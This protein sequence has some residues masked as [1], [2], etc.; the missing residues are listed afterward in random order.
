[1]RIK[2]Q[3]LLFVFVMYFCLTLLPSQSALAIP[4]FLCTDVIEIPQVECQALVALYESTNGPGWVQNNNWLL[5]NTP[6][7]W[8][9]VTVA[10]GVVTQLILPDNRLTGAIPGELGALSNLASLDLSA[11]QLSGAIP[12]QL[13]S[14]TSL[15]S[16][17]LSDNW[18]SGTI[19]PE[20]G[21]LSI[22]AHLYLN[23]NQLSGAIPP[24]LVALLNLTSLDLSVNQLSAAIPSQLGSLAHLTY[25]DLSY[26]QLTGA[27]PLELGNLSALAHLYLNGNQLSGEIPPALGNLTQ[28]ERLYLYDNFLS[29]S[30]PTSLGNLTK[31]WNLWLSGNQLSGSIPPGFGQ[32]HNMV[33]LRLADNQLSGAIPIELGQLAGLWQL[34]LANNQLTGE[35]PVEFGGMTNLMILSLVGNQL[36]GPIPS[37][38]CDLTNLYELDLSA[39]QLSGSIPP[40]LGNLINL[41]I[42]LLNDNQLSGDIPD[43]TGL[44][45]LIP[46]GELE[47]GDGLNLDYNALTVPT[48]YPDE[49]SAL[50]VFLSQYDLNWHT[51]QGFEQ[52]IGTAGGTLTSLDGRTSITVPTNALINYAIFTFTPLP[53]PSY[54]PGAL[55]DAHNSFQLTAEGLDGEPVT[56]FIQP[57]NVTINYSDT[58]VL[59]MVEASLALFYYDTGGL[60]WQDAV[61]TCYPGA[62]TRDPLANT[63]SLPLCHLSDFSVLGL[64]IRY[65]YLPLITR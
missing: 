32:L 16:L 65:I 10:S 7:D 11:N 62:Y 27:I 5:T 36:S 8:F 54:S 59:S 22:L 12:S 48:G 4:A 49:T 31:M 52:I 58:D 15:T 2:P 29:G 6:S 13:G 1:M 25:L 14:L 37:Q 26:N 44:T 45:A 53:D 56:T 42:L 55:G 24:E 28:L 21:N 33:F 17:D 19:P 63:I 43:I 9:G 50:Q 30:I 60:T 57:L 46:P 38:L 18:L 40:E 61:T 34:S 47:G 35:I 64:P 51:L 41:E 23:G 3:T 20:L 39:N